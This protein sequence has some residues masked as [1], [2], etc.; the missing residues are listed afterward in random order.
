MAPKAKEERCGA[1]LAMALIA[2]TPPEDDD[3]DDDGR[4]SFSPGKIPFSFGP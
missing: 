2:T 3:D 1:A 4:G